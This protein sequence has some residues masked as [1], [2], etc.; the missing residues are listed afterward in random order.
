VIAAS[1]PM[2]ISGRTAAAAAPASVAIATTFHGNASGGTSRSLR[3]TP[4]AKN[5]EGSGARSL[6]SASSMK[7]S[8]SFA[9]ISVAP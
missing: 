7:S 8:V 1:A 4:R 2:P 3:I 5:G 6:R 9:M